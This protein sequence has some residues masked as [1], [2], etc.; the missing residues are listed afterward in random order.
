MIH[1]LFVLILSL[2]LSFGWGGDPGPRHRPHHHHRGPVLVTCRI[3][4]GCT[5]RPALRSHL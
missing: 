1:G 3:G 4:R 2:S 5:I